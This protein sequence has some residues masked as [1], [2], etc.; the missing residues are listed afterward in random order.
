MNNFCLVLFKE[1]LYR[2]CK[3]CCSCE[4]ISYFL[5]AS[6]SIAFLSFIHFHS[7]LRQFGTGQF[8]FY[9]LLSLINLFAK[10]LIMRT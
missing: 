6:Y 4:N 3:K 7:I 1:K 8:S 2:V 5:Y 10:F 9:F